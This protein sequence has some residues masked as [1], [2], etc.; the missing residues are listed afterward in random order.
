MLVIKDLKGEQAVLN[1]DKI[2][3]WNIHDTFWSTEKLLET[4][5]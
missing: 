3:L 5:K 2:T 4:L 1:I